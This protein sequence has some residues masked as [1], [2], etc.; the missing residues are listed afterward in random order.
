MLQQ[1]MMQSAKAAGT[2]AK[3]RKV[4]KLSPMLCER[5]KELQGQLKFLRCRDDTDVDHIVSSSI[6]H[7]VSKLEL[8]LHLRRLAGSAPEQWSSIVDRAAKALGSS[9]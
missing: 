7:S 8:K 3:L 6:I 4:M 9:Q 5:F 2:S 1:E